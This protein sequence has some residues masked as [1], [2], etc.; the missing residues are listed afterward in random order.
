MSKPPIALEPNKLAEI[1]TAEASRNEI[2]VIRKPFGHAWGHEYWGKWQTIAYALNALST[3]EGATVLDIGVGVGWTTLFLAEFGYQATGVDIAPANIEI[4][5]NRAE[6][7][8]VNA[9][10]LV[11]DMDTLALGRR[12]DVV[13]VFDALHH[14]TR[15]AT[16]IARIAHHVKPGGW[17][18]FGEP[19]WLHGISPHARRTAKDTGWIERGVSIRSLKSECAANGLGNFRRFYE[20]TSPYQSTRGFAW[21]FARLIGAPLTC[22]PKMSVWIAAQSVRRDDEDGI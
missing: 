10:F 18:L 21:Q 16:V 14:T 9:E 22:S 7:L 15:Q 17:V 2:A 13:L 12:F 6:R 20:G 19:S 3:S 8:G 1:A 4:A 11:A 5:A